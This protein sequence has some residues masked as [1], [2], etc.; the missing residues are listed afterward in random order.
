MM[1]DPNITMEE[2]IKLQAEKAQQRSQMFNWETATYGMI[3]CDNLNF[4]T[5]FE[6]DFP[7]IV[8]ND[9]LASNENVSSEPTI[10]MALLPRDQRHFFLKFKRLE[11]TDADITDFEDRG[12]TDE[13]TVGL[14]DRMLMEHKDA[15]GQSLFTSRSWRRLLEVRGLLV[16]EHILEFFSTF[17]FGKAVLGL[18]TVGEFQ[19]QLEPLEKGD[20][21]AYGRGFSSVG[22]FLWSQTPE[23][24]TVTDL[25]YLRGID[26]DSVNIAYLLARYLRRFA[27]GR[28]REAIISGGQFLPVIDMAEMPDAVAG[29]LEVTKGAPDVDEGAQA[30]PAPVQAPQ[31]PPAAAPTRTMT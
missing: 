30:V 26:V 25:F 31:P 16:H 9:A 20:I 6:A 4:C 8:Y 1:D 7:A 22:D 19:F 10:N 12:L 5:D 29:A 21:S 3:Y 24:V 28:K 13:M 14:S 27:S 18:D 11:Y 15:Q 23:K 17:R 2:Y